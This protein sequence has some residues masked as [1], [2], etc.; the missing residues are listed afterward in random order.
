[1]GAVHPWLRG[2]GECE[3]AKSR[4]E[5]LL[6]GLRPRNRPL[7]HSN[8]FQDFP[9]WD[10]GCPTPC[11]LVGGVKNNHHNNPDHN[12][13]NNNGTWW[14][15][16]TIHNDDYTKERVRVSLGTKDVAIARALRD[17]I[18]EASPKIAT[19]IPRSRGQAMPDVVPDVSESRAAARRYEHT[20]GAMT[21]A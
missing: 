3:V 4:G 10:S 21:A 7:C 19:N 13:W 6:H 14:C 5:I 20:A 8:F 1:M 11:V 17:F 16:Y 9:A 15:H 12:L 18:M 2:S